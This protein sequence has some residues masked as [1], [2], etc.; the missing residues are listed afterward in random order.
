MRSTTGY[1]ANGIE[2]LAANEAHHFSRPRDS[3]S[4][5]VALFSRLRSAWT[6]LPLAASVTV[7]AMTSPDAHLSAAHSRLSSEG[8]GSVADDVSAVLRAQT[9]SAPDLAEGARQLA[10]TGPGVKGHV[11][12]GAGGLE[13]QSGLGPDVPQPVAPKTPQSEPLQRSQ[14]LGLDPR[15]IVVAEQQH[16]QASLPAEQGRPQARSARF[17]PG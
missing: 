4:R 1:D 13:L 17:P 2:H 10:A 14:S 7:T 6:R 3:A 5:A 8:S 11:K 15:H 9:S 16:L 12:V